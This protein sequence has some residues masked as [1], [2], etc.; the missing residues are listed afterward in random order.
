MGLDNVA[1]MVPFCRTVSEL[2]SNVVQ[3]LMNIAMVYT[4]KGQ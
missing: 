4:T 3:T 1:V 2:M